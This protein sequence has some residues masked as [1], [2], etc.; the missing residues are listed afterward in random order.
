MSNYTG[1]VTL[2]KK[3]LLDIKEAFP[4]SFKS[5]LK[6]TPLLFCILI[7]CFFLLFST[8]PSL[9]MHIFVERWTGAKTDS[10]VTVHEHNKKC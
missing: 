4:S 2:I 1:T 5:K 9:V 8:N 6:T 10:P 7:C 3:Y